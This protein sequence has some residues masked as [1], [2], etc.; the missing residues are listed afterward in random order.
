MSGAVGRLSDPEFLQFLARVLPRLRLRAASFKHVR[1]IVKK[2]VGRRLRELGLGI[3]DYELYLDEH[4]EEW[5]WLDQ[6]SRITISRFYRDA[7]VFEHITRVMLPARAERAR[8]EGRSM[9]RV[10]SAGCASGEEPY[11]VSIAWQLALQPRYPE[12]GL[13]LLA[14]DADPILLERARRG[15]YPAGTLRE[16]PADWQS[17]AFAPGLLY[18]LRPEFRTGVSF[19]HADLR[20]VLPDGPFDVVLCRNLAFSYFDDGL[21]RE[22]AEAFWERLLP[23][24]SVV[25]G[26]GETLPAGMDRAEIAHP[27]VYQKGS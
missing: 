18:C 15:C 26:L 7:A 5:G 11:G 13:Q 17:R 22:L 16:L 20:S 9:L 2:R 19:Q 21:Q 8:A 14:T 27:C 12:L 25:V 1:G 4:P 3:A 23:G 6:R 24:G 10:W